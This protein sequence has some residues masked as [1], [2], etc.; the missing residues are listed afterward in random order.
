MFIEDMN[1]SEL[2]KLIRN[3]YYHNCINKNNIKG[4][5][6]ELLKNIALGNNEFIYYLQNGINSKFNF[7]IDNDEW[8]NEIL[9][10]ISE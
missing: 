4:K 7:S 8:S 3:M 9:F 1:Q 10:Q 5:D 6:L 2:Q